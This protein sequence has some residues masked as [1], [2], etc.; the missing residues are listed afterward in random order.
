MDYRRTLQGTISESPPWTCD[1]KNN[2]N[3]AHCEGQHKREG[4]FDETFFNL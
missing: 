4:K 1:N 2:F 3:Y